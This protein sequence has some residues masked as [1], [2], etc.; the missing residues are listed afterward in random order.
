MW[1]SRYLKLLTLSTGDP[2]ICRGVSVLS[3]FFLQKYTTISLVLLTFR[4][5]RLSWPHSDRSATSWR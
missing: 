1:T 3:L 2:L 5:R 4:K